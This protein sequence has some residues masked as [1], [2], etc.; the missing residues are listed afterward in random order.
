MTLPNFDVPADS[1]LPALTDALKA[2][3]TCTRIRDLGFTASKHITMYGE[4]FEL[5][6]DPF[7]EGDCTS[8]RAIGQTYPGVR[9]LRLPVAVLVGLRDRFRR[10]AKV[11]AQ[12]T[13]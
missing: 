9:T 11:G 3:E 10:P 6:S 1:T 8:V 13:P 5:V 12:D 2:A 4:R 7:S